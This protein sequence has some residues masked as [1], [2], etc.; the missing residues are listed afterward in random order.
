[1]DRAAQA[2]FHETLS[3]RTVYLRYLQHLELDQ[4]V[5]H[6][7]LARLCFIDYGRDMALV[8]EPSAG[9]RRPA[10]HGHRTSEPH[11][12]TPATRRCRRS[13]ASSASG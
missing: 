1:V 13:Q 12:F 8:A 9:G 5:A 7:R 11:G 4:R 2:R 3:G 6:Q 10:D